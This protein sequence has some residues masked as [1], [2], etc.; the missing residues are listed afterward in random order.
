MLIFHELK[1]VRAQ[2][3][4]I[5]AK[6]QKLFMGSHALEKSFCEICGLETER[7]GTSDAL[8]KG[9]NA[10]QITCFSLSLSTLPV[11]KLLL[12]RI[13]ARA[14]VW[15]DKAQHSTWHCQ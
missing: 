4:E 15:C 1:I 9:T 11:R 10:Q 8:I 5:S 12:A 7:A 2:K 13:Y 14:Y 3:T 6:H